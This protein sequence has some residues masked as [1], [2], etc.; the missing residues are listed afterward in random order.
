MDEVAEMHVDDVELVGAPP[1]LGEHRQMR[2]DH[3]LKAGVEPERARSRRHQPRRGDRLAA[4]EQRHL[5]PSADQAFRQ[6]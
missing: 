2:G 3:G 1:D 6:I 4:G 5:M